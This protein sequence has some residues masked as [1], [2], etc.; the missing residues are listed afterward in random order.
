MT[1]TT[2]PA[3]SGYIP[4]LEGVV[5]AETCLSSVDGQAGELIIAGFKVEELALN[6]LFEETVYLLWNGQLP[7]SQQLAAFKKQLDDNAALPPAT[8]DLLRAAAKQ[9]VPAMDALRMAASTLSLNTPEMP[10][11]DPLKRDAIL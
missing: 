11:V 5:A 8:V 4:G 9:K 2:A 7:N 10:G 1:T 3:P 6:A